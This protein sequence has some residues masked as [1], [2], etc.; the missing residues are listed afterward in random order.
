MADWRPCSERAAGLSHAD[1][2]AKLEGQKNFYGRRK[3]SA[4]GTSPNASTSTP[5]PSL[6]KKKR[7]VTDQS[8]SNVDRT[9][10]RTRVKNKLEDVY[11]KHLLCQHAL[12]P[13]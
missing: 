5:T 11:G 13:T 6:Q 12:E 3:A 8:I 10:L 2:V 9:K 4:S 7:A 1:A